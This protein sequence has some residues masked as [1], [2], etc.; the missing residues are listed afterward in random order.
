MRKINVE[1]ITE[2][3][4]LLSKETN[5]ALTGDV[6][7]RIHSCMECEQDERAKEILNKIEENIKIAGEEG[8]PLCQDTGLACV[9]LELGQEVFLEGG[10]L[11]AAINAGVRKGYEEGYLRKSVVADPLNRVNTRDNTPANI[12]VEI[13][14]GD[15][16]KI[17]FAPKG[18]GSEN[19]SQIKMLPPSAGA[20][21][22]KDFVVQVVKDAGGNPCPPIVVG[23]GIGGTF[24]SAPLLAKKALMLPMETAN[25]EPFYQEMEAELLERI[26]QLNIGPQGFGGNTTALAVKIIQAPTHIAGLPVAVNI[27][28]HVNRHGVVII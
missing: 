18:F 10:D 2:A 21:G 24:D 5:Y 28:C 26:N 8:I 27:N 13:V 25:P 11:V 1:K 12:H 3:V 7:D 4:A 19:M 23:V 6:C 9:F 15:Q 17:T 20:E 22:V 16:V 14:K